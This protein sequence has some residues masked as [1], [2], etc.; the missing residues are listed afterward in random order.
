MFQKIIREYKQSGLLGVL[1]RGTKYNFQQASK[2]CHNSAE[3]IS[4]KIPIL[5]T[6]KE[7]LN[8]N[9]IFK[10]KHIGSRCFVIGN[11][12]SLKKQDLSLL[13]NDIT[14]VANAF[15]KHPIVE[16]WQPSYYCFADP[17]F[18]EGS[19]AVRNFFQNLQQKVHSSKFLVPVYAKNVIENQKL[20]PVEQTYYVAYR[21]KISEGLN[22][23]IDLTKSIPSVINV[24]QLEIMWAMYMGFSQIYLMG[25]DHDWLSHQGID[26]HFYSG[27]TIGNH[28]KEHGDLKKFGYK[29]R[30]EYVLQLWQG[31]D[32]ILK[33]ALGK[34][35][36]I[37][38]ATE[39]GFLDVFKR[40]NYESIF[41]QNKNK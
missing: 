17:I 34:N 1:L 41:L 38:N 33:I 12:A 23:N 24:V 21:G 39:G 14:I 20:L 32:K 10:N 2:L 9:H 37:I 15:Y 40:M 16:K 8:R 5:S 7:L 13:S 18:F 30:L 31:Y 22:Y 3:W 26:R 27:I 25:L 28:L 35:I 19:I 4:T 6:D 29:C 36:N 11:G